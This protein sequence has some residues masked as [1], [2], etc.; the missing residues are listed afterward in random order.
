MQVSK[1]IL[2]IFDLYGCRNFALMTRY[3]AAVFLHLRTFTTQPWTQVSS[4][5]SQRASTV[6]GFTSLLKAGNERSKQQGKQETAK[7]QSYGPMPPNLWQG[8]VGFI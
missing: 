7:Q 8:L 2:T 5:H 1:N 4:Y 6:G 3:D